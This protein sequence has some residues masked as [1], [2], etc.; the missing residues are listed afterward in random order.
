MDFSWFKLV[1]LRNNQQ[2][3]VLRSEWLRDYNLAILKWTWKESCNWWIDVEMGVACSRFPCFPVKGRAAAFW[4][5]Y[6]IIERVTIINTLKQRRHESQAEDQIGWKK[7]LTL[8]NIFKKNFPEE[9]SRVINKISIY[10]ISSHLTWDESVCRLSTN[11]SKILNAR[12]T[13]P[14]IREV[15]SLT[16]CMW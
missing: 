4:T 1:F 12:L 2:H 15:K 10:L 16:R 8:Y 7:G 5:C 9:L 14:R 6:A 11:K 3:L 13:C